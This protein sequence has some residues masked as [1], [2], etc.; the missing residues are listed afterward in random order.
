M[1][2]IP[3]DLGVGLSAGVPVP[4]LWEREGRT[5]RI[6][7]VGQAEETTWIHPAIPEEPS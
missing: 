6:M 7:L 1:S 4:F 3:D 2:E 5:V